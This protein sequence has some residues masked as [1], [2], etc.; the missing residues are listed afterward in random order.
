VLSGGER[1]RI[2]FGRL[3]LSEPN[4]IIM[5][6]ATAALHIDSEFRLLTLLFE[7]LP[8]ATIFS[9]GHR[10]G[11]RELH[12]RLLTLQR[13]ATGGRIVQ[14]K[15]EVGTLGGDCRALRSAS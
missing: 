2:A 4:I 3:L 14:T 13:R 1:Q 6:E 8:K 15:S 7:R 9:V 10:P 12:S 5:D 11:L